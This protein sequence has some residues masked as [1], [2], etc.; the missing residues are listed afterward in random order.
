MVQSHSVA[1]FNKTTCIPD[2]ILYS[3]NEK[4]VR[5]H[6]QTLVDNLEITGL[7]DS[8]ACASILG[9]QAH[10][11]FLKM[12]YKLHVDNDTTFSVA[13]GDKLHC[14]GYMFIPITYNSMTHIIKFFVIPSIVVDVIFG[15]DFWKTFQLAP[16]IFDNLELSKAPSSFYSLNVVDNEPVHTIKSFESLSDQQKE[17]ANSVVNK[18]LDISSQRIG[19]GRTNLIEHIID[20]GDALPIKIKQ[21]PLSPEKKDALCKELDRMLELDVVTPSESPWNNPAILVKKSNG[22][23]RFCLDCRKLNSVTK[24][25]SYSIP[26]IPQILDSL[27]EAKFLSSID[28]SSSFWQIPLSEDSQEKTSFTVP[29]RGLFKFK[30]MPFGLCGAPARQQRLMDRLFNQNFCSDITN[31]RV[32]CYID[33]IVICSSDFETHLILL[34][35]VLDKLK[36]AKLSINF[37]KCSFFRKSLRYLGYMVD[38]FGL[39]TD[40][41]K[42]AAV[43][44][45]PTPKSAQEVK[46]FLGTCSWYR[47]FIRN[48]STIAAPLNRLTSKGK[49]APKFEWSEQAEVAFNTLKNALVTA[50]VLAVPNFDKPFKVHCDASAYGV[51]G[52]LTQ[53]VDGHEHPIAYVSRSLNKNERNYSATEREALAVIFAVEK[54]QAYFGSRTVTIITDHA[55]LKWFLNLENPSGRLARWGCRLSQFNFVIEHRKGSDNVVPDSLSR[56]IKVDVI[57]DQ[58]SSSGKQSIVDDWYDKIFNGCKSNPANFPNFCILN[59]KLFRFSKCKYQL[60]SEFDWK[61]VVHKSDINRILKENH[62]DP[63]A[64]HFGVFKTHRRLSLRYFWRGMYKDVVDYVKN[65]DVCA[66]YKHTTTATP[67]LLG[68]P[69]VCS[70]PFQVIS[71][72]LVGP[73]PRSRSGFTFLFVVT[74]CFSKYT[75]LFPLRRATGAAVVKAL[76]NF[77]F[78]N[79]SVPET[80][81]V[82]NGSQFTGSEFRSLIKRYNIPNLHYTPLYTPQVNL[83]ERYNKTIMTAVAAFVKD[84]HRSWDE[85]L[86][87]VQF[88]INS[89]VNESTG[90]SPFFLVHGREPVLNGSFYKDTDKDYEVGMPREEYAGNFGILQDI[91]RQVRENL[92]QAHAENAT[93]YNLRRR[94]AKY[95]VGDIVWKRTYSQSDA[96][97]FFT[98]KLAPKYE[99]CRVVKVLSPLVYELV[100][101]ADNH[102]IGT[103]HIKDFKK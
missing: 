13:N 97:K 32:F 76:E 19:L 67:G 50:P 15:C 20:T 21:Y 42:V 30:V 88:A 22:D 6:L 31:G 61:E 5:P 40:P 93:H 82:D 55:S 79:H 66:A 85:N 17:L 34:N 38:E 70:R 103:W 2:T 41:E 54:F 26:Y 100:R 96:E 74:C 23:W 89:A 91:F 78:L 11:V 48:F 8:G 77:V 71:A 24:G 56:L 37:E 44:N 83:V 94:P 69:K 12:G 25:D 81:I 101:V 47:R 58:R 57:N 18:F 45:F 14:M 102:P 36:M 10:K 84:N 87:K 95:A 75:M 53:E 60:L 4:D 1:K 43:M 27:K 63:T 46:I 65:C 35:R 39:R 92:F 9:N 73:L 28:L 68:K 49:N 64:G 59:N 62:A 3:I 80:V 51:G 33:D 90:F 72:D 52:M 29:G 7:L 98:T 99:K 86:Y 16:G